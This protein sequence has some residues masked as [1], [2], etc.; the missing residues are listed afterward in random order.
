MRRYYFGSS[1]HGG[2]NG[3][4]NVNPRQHP[5]LLQQQL[6]PGHIPFQS[7][8]SNRNGQRAALHFRN[9]VMNGTLPP[10]SVYP[11][12]ARQTLVEPTKAAMGF[13]DI[14]AIL[15]SSNPVPGER[16]HGID[17]FIQAMLQ[18]DWGPTL[19][20]SENTGSTHSSRRSSRK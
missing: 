13:P 20:Y 18:Y 16:R 15:T 4:F 11:T 12:L 8:S 10:N 9:W 7:A 5:E 14:P 19:D 2:G 6:W 17:R 3:G 1:P